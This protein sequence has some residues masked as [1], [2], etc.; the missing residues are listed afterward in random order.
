MTPRPEFD[1]LV[2]HSVAPIA[3]S[4]PRAVRAQK[5]LL[6]H[7]ESDSIPAGL[8]RSVQMF[9]AAFETDEPREYMAPFLARKHEKV[10]S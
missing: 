5:T 6:R 4:G 7:W 8:D 3:A 9:G 10:A 2:E 1:A